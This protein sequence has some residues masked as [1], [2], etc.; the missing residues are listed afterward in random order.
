MRYL[1]IIISFFVSGILF[2][3]DLSIIYPDSGMVSTDTSIG[4][5]WNGDT[6]NKTFDLEIATDENFSSV[7]QYSSNLTHNYDTVDFSLFNQVYYW[8]VREYN[9]STYSDWTDTRSFYIANLSGIGQLNLWLRSDSGITLNGSNV[10]VW[11]DISG[12]GNDVY[13]NTVSKQPGF[14]TEAINGLPAVTFNGSSQYLKIPDLAMPELE[15][16]I[17]IVFKAANTAV[18]KVLIAR[19]Y[20]YGALY[21]MVNVAGAFEYRVNNV[22]N[23]SGSIVNDEIYKISSVYYDNVAETQRVNLVHEN[24]ITNSSGVIN[25]N[26]LDSAVIGCMAGSGYAFYYDGEIA[27][28]IMYD[29]I[30]DFSDIEIIEDYLHHRYAPPVKLGPDINIPYGFCDTI[31]DAGERFTDYIWNTG[32]TTQTI[33]VNQ[34]GTYSVTVTDIFGF[35]SSDS[36]IVTYPGN[37]DFTDTLICLYDIIVIDPELDSNYTYLWSTGSTDSIIYVSDT[38]SY[39]VTITD[40][41]SC[42]VVSDTIS[43]FLDYYPSNA[44][45]GIDTNF[46]SGNYISLQVGASETISYLWSPGGETDSTKIIDTSGTYYVTV[47]NINGCVAI[48]TIDVNIIGVAPATGF[49]ANTV[50]FGDSTIFFDTS[51]PASPSPADV[52]TSWEWIFGDGDTSY[53]Q[54]PSHLYNS[55]GEYQVT[56]NISSNAGCSASITD[57]VFVKQI[58]IADFDVDM[59]CIGNPY[60]F[61]DLSTVSSPDSIISWLWDFGNGDTSNFQDTVYTY[62]LA[63]YYTVSLTVESS[64]SCTDQKQEQIE[65]VNSYSLPEIF[66]LIYPDDNAVLADTIIDFSWN[67]SGNA[68]NYLLQIAEDSLFSNIIISQETVLNNYQLLITNYQLLYWRVIAYNICNDSIISDS[69]NFKICNPQIINGL[70]LWLRSDSGITLNGSNVFAWEDISGNGNDVY[71]NTISN[72]PGFITEAINGL[73]AVTFNGSLQYLKIPDIAMPEFDH[74]IFIVFKAANTAV[75]KVLISRAYSYG[76]LYSMVNISGA[77]EYRVNNIANISSSIVN[78][79]LYK[80]S[81][82]YYDTITETQR[83]NLVHEN[84]VLNPLGTINYNPSDSAVIGCM[85]GSGYANYYNGEIAEILMYD[86]ILDFS[87]IEIIENYLHY[88]Y[89]PP[90][91]LGPDINISYGFCDTTLDAKERFIDYIWSTGETTQMISA[92]V[93]GQYKVTATDIFGFTSTDSVMV[94][95]NNI[96]NQ[97]SDITICVDDI[98]TWDTELDT[99]YTFSWQNSDT[100]SYQEIS[101]QG[102]Y[103]VQITDSFGCPFDSDTIT[104]TIDLFSQI[105]TLG[106]DDTLCAGNSLTL[107]TGVGSNFLWSTGETTSSIIIDT[108]GLYW[109]TV[110][111]SIGCIKSDTVDIFIHG[112]APTLGFSNNITCIGDTTF[113]NDTSFVNGSGN[114]I[115][116]EWDFGDFATSI[117]QNPTNYYLNTG[118]YTVSLTVET[119]SGCFNTFIH[120]VHIHSLPV[121]NFNYTNLCSNTGIQFNDNSTSLDGNI[122]EWNWDFDNGDTSII[123][124]PVSIFNSSGNYQIEL[125]VNTEYGCSH[126][127][128]ENIYVKESPVAK[129]SFSNTCVGDKVYFND[130]SVTGIVHPLWSWHWD[131]GNS[132]TSSDAN[133]VIVF[134][135]VGIYPIEFI[136][137]SL[138]GC[139]DTINTNVS[140]NPVPVALFYDSVICVDNQYHFTDSSFI[141]SGAIASWQWNINQIIFTDQNPFY[142][143]NETGDYN[144]QLIVS[145]DSSCVDTLNKNITVYSLPDASFSFSPSWGIPLSSIN[146]TNNND[147]DSYFWVFGNGNDYTGENPTYVYPDSGVYDITLIVTDIHG[148]TDSSKQTIGVFVPACDIAVLNVS[149]TIDEQYLSISADIVNYGNIPL[150]QFYLSVDIGKGQV[151][152]TVSEQLLE[153]DIITYNFNSTFEIN[154]DLLPEKICV[155]AELITCTDLYPKNNEYCIIE[156]DAFAIYNIYPN[157]FTDDIY[158]EI[159]IPAE[160]K[161]SIHIYD[162]DGRLVD[163]YIFENVPKGFNRLKINTQSYAQGAYS[164]VVKYL[165]QTISKKMVKK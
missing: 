1:L 26:V 69:N 56:L 153:G 152:E 90:V 19:T 65:V 49:S 95:Y 150:E 109:L 54:N 36:L 156:D 123:Q 17:F 73:P 124:N 154:P 5:F 85:A 115:S 18:R 29:T 81:S 44:S 128:S 148:C 155:K 157:P 88:R 20:S 93:S 133:P 94:Y 101:T 80:I 120:D 162:N 147:N 111:D 25:Y 62:G 39:W 71:Q 86:T 137:T 31:L 68:S 55:T 40:T 9:G 113:F 122:V 70:Q 142:T 51:T 126:L 42:S 24:S 37:L 43:V 7:I 145:S 28:I 45:L 129:F 159:S 16:T 134:D 121:S 98:I 50:C 84:S 14:I 79:E 141:S 149:K 23:V 74:T 22:A 163:N 52:I 165:N 13:Q 60:T 10:L 136:V 107:A 38:G 46:C 59:A 105:A 41:V 33:S 151:K 158:I 138:N 67:Y 15:H 35:T 63:G 57:T 6:I 30:L 75:K 3:Q 127:F 27:E 72:Q 47:T 61:T 82:V 108:S 89:A 104:V 118:I 103:Y 87:D 132:V 110:S 146:F 164:V 106:M 131:F 102:Q 119:D 144:I 116:W 34:N 8:H 112:I 135:T 100:L 97:I 160:D 140:I 64:N 77:F 92:N 66:S 78:D 91:N 130:N 58:P 32:A 11:S 48:D 53:V 117:L 12:N 21:S 76:A 143:F 4:F 125:L 161:V 114:I 99:I 139:P 2:S 96:P 83:I